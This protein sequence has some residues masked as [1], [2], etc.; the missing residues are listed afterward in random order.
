[1]TGDAGS[2]SRFEALGMRVAVCTNR[3]L[4]VFVV[5]FGAVAMVE[6]VGMAHFTHAVVAGRIVVAVDEVMQAV[7][8]QVVDLER[9]KIKVSI[10]ERD[11]RV[12]EKHKGFSFT[13]DAIPGE[14]FSCKL[15][16]R[17]PAANPVT[18]SFPVELVVE[19]RDPRMADGMTA[20]V[21]FPLVDEKKTIKVPSAWLSEE[22]GKIGL[23]VVNEGKALFRQVKLG[24]Y[25]DQ[26]VEILSGVNDQEE[27]I[28]NPAGLKSGDPVEY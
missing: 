23:Y 24:A 26:R 13:V 11:I 8:T 1:M 5:T 14:T 20:R 4:E 17:S 16:F 27:V 10:G 28:T 9:L 12:L 6:R 7:I 22:N 21:T 19:K 18:R 25:Y 3:V 15:Y 2:S